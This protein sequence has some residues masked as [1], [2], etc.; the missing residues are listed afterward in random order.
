MHKPKQDSAGL[1]PE[2][3]KVPGVVAFT[4]HMMDK[5]G[6]VPPRFAPRF[7]KGGGVGGVGGPGFG[8]ELG[9]GGGGGGWGRGGVGGGW[10]W[11]WV[12]VG[13]GGGWGGGGG[14]GGG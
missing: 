5:A 6:R 4:G 1:K 13:G 14:G 12:W 10:G 8:E 2:I 9:E 11:G 7:P 3:G